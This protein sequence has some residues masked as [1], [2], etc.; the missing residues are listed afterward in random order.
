MPYVSTLQRKLEVAEQGGTA[1][2]QHLDYLFFFLYLSKAD[3]H[4]SAKCSSYT[5]I[6]LTYLSQLAITVLV[7]FPSKT[8]KNPCYY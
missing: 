7:L 2:K 6:T 4:Y 5:V 8:L 3:K 1:E